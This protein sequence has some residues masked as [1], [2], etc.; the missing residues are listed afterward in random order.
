MWWM[1]IFNRMHDLVSRVGETEMITYRHQENGFRYLDDI[2]AD[3]L[4]SGVIW[5][6]WM[7]HVTEL[8]ER[9]AE[10]KQVVLYAMNV[11]YGKYHGQ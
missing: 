2:S 5:I 9:L 6:Y 4:E 11:D 3:E 8:S 10:R 7:S 1:E